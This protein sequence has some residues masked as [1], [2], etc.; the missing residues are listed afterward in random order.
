MSFPAYPEYKDSGVEWLGEVPEHWSVSAL[1]RVARLESGDAI[2]SDHISEEGEYAVYGGNG[3]RGFSSGYTH[4]GFYPLIGRQGALCG[5]VNYAKGR[6]WASEHAVVV[7]PGRQID[8]FWL[9]ELLRSMNLNQYATSA[10]QPGLSVETIENLYVPVPPD[11]EQ[12]K[13]A[14]LLD[15]ETA[16]IDALIEE[17]QRLIELLK[18][19]RQAV[20]SHAVTKGLDPDVPMKDSGVEWLGEVP[21]HW[22]VVKFVRCAK[23]AEG[24]VDPKQEPYRSMMLVAPNHIESGTGRLMARETAEEQGAESGKYYC[25]AGDVIYSKIRPSLRK[26][27]VA[28]EDCLC[29]ADMYP[30]RAQSGVYGDY[31]RWTI[32]SESFSTLA[33]LESERVAMPKV[34]RESIEEIRIP[35]PPPEEQLQIS[36]TLEKETARIDALMEEAESGIQLLQERRSALISAAVTGKIDVRDW[37]PP[38]AAEPEQERE[39]AAL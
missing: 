9:G 22:D 38:A 8:G 35:M 27:C 18:E 37:A 11:E 28:Y 39:G 34:N 26:A 23:I 7:W 31:L 12:Q 33:F 29:S 17:Q 5:N 20:I 19:K 15:H 25:Y 30:L 36:R 14:E 32:L 1:K 13:I 16:R 6:F 4:D 2:S 10:A 24:Q 21:A 3:I